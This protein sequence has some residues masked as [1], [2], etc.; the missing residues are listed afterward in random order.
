MSAFIVS[1]N[2]VLLMAIIHLADLK[3]TG[4]NGI[5]EIKCPK[6]YDVVTEA[7]ALLKENYNSWNYRYNESD[8]N[9]DR[10]IATV[11][12]TEAGIRDL[13]VE[14]GSIHQVYKATKCYEYQT[15]EHPQWETSWSHATCKEICA[16]LDALMSS[17]IDPSTEYEAADWGI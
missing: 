7:R 3:K 14:S 11:N 15:C 8:E 4:T 9:D 13:L 16:K 12:I 17:T 6:P 10:D 1:N 2:N 5:A